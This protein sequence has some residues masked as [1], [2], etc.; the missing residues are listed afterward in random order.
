[1]RPVSRLI[2]HFELRFLPSLAVL[3]EVQ[4]EAAPPP[5]RGPLPLLLTCDYF[6]VQGIPGPLP[7]I[8]ADTVL[9]AKQLCRPGTGIQEATTMN[10][11]R[12]TRRLPRGV[13][14]VAFIRAH[15]EWVE[16]DPSSSGMVLADGEL[17]SGMLAAR[18]TATGRALLNVPTTVVMSCC[19]TSGNR[20][21]NGGETLG[22]APLAMMAGA[23][24]LI[25]TS[26]DIRHTAFTVAFDNMLIDL[27]MRPGD[28]FAALWQQQLCL[29][30]AWRGWD[31]RDPAG[32]DDLLPTPEIWAHYQAFGA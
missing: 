23:R 26:V 21:R 10:L 31:H 4:A 6:P 30:D 2:E 15:Y 5:A 16:A 27:A 29:L 22:L 18:D 1:M 11:V 13:E 12:W 25:V 8:H 7:A 24:R 3:N 28:H 19:S 9:A 20:E 14:G 32:G 17:F